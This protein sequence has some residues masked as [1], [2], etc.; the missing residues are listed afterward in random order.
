MIVDKKDQGYS[1][2]ELAEEFNHSTSTLQKWK[3]SIEKKPYKRKPSKIDD[4]L[5]RKDVEMYPDAYQHE[6]A[7]RFNCTGSGIGVALRRIGI[8][9]KKRP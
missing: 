5:L 2:R 1:Y 8:T 4:D 6:I 9:R 3:K 7:V